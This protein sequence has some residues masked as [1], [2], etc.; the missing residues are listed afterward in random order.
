MKMMNNVFKLLRYNLVVALLF[1]GSFPSLVNAQTPTFQDCLGALPICLTSYA[2]GNVVTGT[3]NIFNEIN[4]STSCL[5]TGERNDVWYIVTTSTNGN[6]NFTISPV[7]A[8]HNYDWAVYNLTSAVCSDI[9]SNPSLEV[10][11]N[12]SNVAGNTGPNGLPG[13]QNSPVI[14]AVAGQTFLIN[15]SGFSS[16]N[17]SGYTIDFT[18]ST[19]SIADNTPPVLSSITSMNCGATTLTASFSERIRCSTVQPSDFTLTGPGGPYT[20]NSVTGNSCALN[21]TYSR[22]FA[23]TFSPAIP[24][25][26]TYF[27]TLNGTVSDLCNNNATVPQAFPIPISGINITFQ[28]TDVTCFG[29]NN[30]S[31]TAVITGA[32]GPYSYQWSPSGGSGASAQFLTSGTYTVTVTS[33]LGCSAT[34]SV[35][36]N[37][38]LTGL[39]ASAVITPSNG[40]ASNGSAAITVTNGQ[41]P[42]T[43]SWWPSGGNAATANNLSAGGYMVTITDANQCVLNYFLNVGSTSGPSVNISNFSNVS[44]FGGNDGSATVAVSGASGTFSYAWSPS[45][46][47]AATAPNLTAGNYTVAVTVAP[48]CT[49]N[50]SVSITQPPS[51][52]SVV[53]NS[54]NTSCG[55]NNGSVN[56]AVSGGVGPYTYQWSPSVSFGNTASNL[57]NGTYTVTVSDANGCTHVSTA[58]ITPSTQPVLTPGNHNNVSCFGLT[59]GST[60]VTVTGGTTPLSCIWSSGQT[61]YNLNNIAAGTYTVTITD[62]LGCSASYTDVISQPTLLS[63]TILNV[64]NVK[65][66]GESTGA[67]SLSATGGTGPYLWSWSGSSSTTS[68]ISNVG[69]GIY[70]VT[71]T[72]QQGCSAATQINIIQPAAALTLQGTV[73]ETSCGNNDGSITTQSTGGTAPYSYL[74]STGSVASSLTTLFAGI[75]TITVTD[76]NGCTQSQSFTVQASNAPVLS[77]V[78]TTNITC[79]GGTNGTADM[80]VTGGIAPYTWSWQNNSSTGSS[81]T[82]LAAGTYTVTVADASGCQAFSQV[83]ITEPNAITIQLSP[84]VAIC[85]GGN[86]SISSSVSGGSQPY[87]YSW[88]NGATT[89]QVNVNPSSTT[90]YTVTV[91]DNKGCSIS[92]GPL[93]VSVLPPLTLAATYP[94]SICKGNNAQVVLN[95]TGGD[96]NYSYNWSNGLSGSSNA[97]SINSDTTITVIVSDGCTTP[98]IQTQIS[99]VA[100]VP[101]D[102]TFTLNQQE[103]CEPFVAQ[104]NVPPGTP[105]GYNYSWNF[106]DNFTSAQQDPSH[107]YLHYGNYNVS[108]TVSYPSA[109][110]C[111]TLINFPAAVKVNQVPVARFIYDPPVPTLNHPDVFFTDRS[112]A[113]SGWNWN[114]GDQ[115]GDVRE[116]N[117]RHTYSDTG[118][119][120]VKLYVK[121]LEGC[122]D[123]AYEV[124]HVT[125]EMQVFIPNAFTPDGSGVNDYF[126]V[127]GVGFSTYE[128]SIYDRWGK[129]VHYSKNSEHAWDGTDD[130]THKP[131]PQG[132][133]V[134][135]I[136]I[137]DNNGDVHNKFDHVTLIR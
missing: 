80:S 56:L 78:A 103:G 34:S 19:A 111:S 89:A 81:A 11:C 74:W 79:H 99:I 35:T 121:S 127:Y 36:I 106:G 110:G 22:D 132:V 10:A 115:S 29:G 104:F 108:L 124:V 38:P 84:D 51:G 23:I 102:L 4:P 6:L 64:V 135:K 82:N 52:L 24:G 12:Y 105:S 109:T 133:Y 130:S 42:I 8:A 134:Y 97:I 100:L 53:L 20:I 67:A 59:D 60:G 33:G 47:N 125:E 126:Q 46:G 101:P 15:V 75:Y 43:Y 72:D 123:T 48:G 54:T 55:N 39:S 69:A 94:D 7:N 13:A 90:S 63:G 30:G 40:C 1:V 62:A 45:G 88:T 71:I 92:S 58:T 73:T 31:A 2:N 57:P 50:A 32:P 96:G 120:V 83:V 107:T 68:S 28:K 25:A 21:G 86:A 95:A 112:T 116:Q 114:F 91:I 49:L 70:N 3:G 76:Q 9:F 122:R 65:C 118:L 113:V 131:V 37:Q 87:T 137:T 16:I 5:L 61:S 66:F 26:G 17:Q 136:T 14:P 129:Q 44:C 98:Q 128:M 77:V 18:A 85:I 41:A 119:Y 27:L 117:P 93:Q